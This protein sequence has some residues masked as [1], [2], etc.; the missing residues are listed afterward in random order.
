[1]LLPQIDG[2]VLLRRILQVA[3]LLQKVLLLC[4]CATR[5]AVHAIKWDCLSCPPAVRA[6]AVLPAMEECWVLP[7]QAMRQLSQ[8]CCP[9]RW[10]HCPPR[11]LLDVLCLLRNCLLDVQWPLPLT[12]PQDL[13]SSSSNLCAEGRQQRQGTQRSDIACSQQAVNQHHHH[14]QVPANLRHTIAC[15]HAQTK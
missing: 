13:L 5:G 15:K 7:P 11:V 3:D 9:H 1:M 6:A 10:L 2:T 14:T 4:T 8:R 12:A